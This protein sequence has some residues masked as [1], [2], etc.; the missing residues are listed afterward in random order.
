MSALLED[1]FVN[2]AAIEKVLVHL[3]IVNWPYYN[4]F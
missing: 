3:Y 2:T 4:G 1:F